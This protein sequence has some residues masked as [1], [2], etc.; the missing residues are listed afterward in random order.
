M[1]KVLQ[2]IT[3]EL[4]LLRIP[5]FSYVISELNKLDVDIHKSP[6]LLSFKNFL[7]KI[8][9]PLPNTYCTIFNPMSLKLLT[10]LRFGL[11]HLN[12]SKFAG[13]FLNCF[14]HKCSCS[15]STTDIIHFFCTAII[16]LI[17]ENSL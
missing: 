3:L 11:N 7:F 6:N 8:G 12:K 17:L 1:M 15:L 13:K 5:F 10:I 16:I 4:M 14:D 2:D 9:R